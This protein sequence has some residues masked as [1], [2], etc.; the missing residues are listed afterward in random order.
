MYKERSEFCENNRDEME[1]FY[2][3]FMN[4]DI[5]WH[6]PMTHEWR[7]LCLFFDWFVIWF[8]QVKLC[9]YIQHTTYFQ[10]VEIL[11]GYFKAAPSYNMHITT[12]CNGNVSVHQQI[13]IQNDTFPTWKV[14]IFCD[15]IKRIKFLTKLNYGNESNWI[16]NH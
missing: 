11:C 6:E 3:Q 15:Q 8:L 10:S 14:P 9:Q 4:I 16:D 12:E 2:W 5:F 7:G 1:S 13:N